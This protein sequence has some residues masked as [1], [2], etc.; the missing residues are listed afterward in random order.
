MQLLLRDVTEVLLDKPDSAAKSEALD[1]LYQAR[2]WTIVRLLRDFNDIIDDHPIVREPMRECAL[3]H[4]LRISEAETEDAENYR[5]AREKFAEIFGLTPEAQNLLEFA[6]IHESESDVGCYL[7][8]E[9]EIFRIQNRRALA[10]IMD[11]NILVVMNAFHELQTCQL[12]A[13]VPVNNGFGRFDD[14]VCQVFETPEQNPAELFCSPLKGETLP[15]DSFNIAPED[16]NYITRLMKSETDSPVHIRS[17]R[18]DCQH[19]WKGGLQRQTFERNRKHEH[20]LK[21]S[22]QLCCRG[23][24]GIDESE[25]KGKEKSWLHSL[26]EKPNNRVIWITN[27]VEHIHPSVIRRFS[28]SIFFREAGRKEREKILRGI[29]SRHNV[30][31]YFDT[32]IIKYFTKSYPVPAS[33]V[34]GAITQAKTLGCSRDEF[35][36]SAEQFVKSY[37]QLLHGGRRIIRRAANEVRDFTLSGVTLDGAVIDDIMTRSRRADEAMRKANGS[38]E[39]GCATI[40]FYGPPGTGKTALARHIAYDPA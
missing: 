9:L 33:V 12:I 13:D 6:Y 23:R 11:T 15:L 17:D 29:I 31:E 27:H 7:E 24:A 35:V 26:L 19:C 32:T 39:G 30:Q 40:L 1:D 2:G 14:A 25:H 5:L 10:V 20:S 4:C 36:P 34:E 8:R 21:E 38:L 16:I 22:R 18:L 28:Y 3:K 37:I